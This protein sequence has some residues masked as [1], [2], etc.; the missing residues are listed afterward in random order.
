MKR[1]ILSAVC[2]LALVFGA[3]ASP[4][5]VETVKD[6]FVTASAA[7][8]DTFWNES[9]TMFFKVTGS[10]T[11]ALI[12]FRN[13]SG[14]VTVPAEV[15]GYKVT[16]IEKDYWGI[17]VDDNITE[18]YLPEGMTYICEQAFT[19]MSALTYV[20]F[21]STL[22]YIGIA[23]FARTNIKS[24]D[25][26]GTRLTYVGDSAFAYNASLKSISFPDTLI[27]I[28]G[29]MCEECTELET[30]VLPAE[31]EKIGYCAFSHTK[32]KSVDIPGTCEEIESHSFND[33]SQLESVTLNEGIM[34]IGASAFRSAPLI[35]SVV[36]PGS[37]QSISESAFKECSSLSSVTLN[38]GLKTIG[39]D[40]FRDTALTSIFI[41][42]SVTSIGD[43][44]FLIGQKS[45]RIQG[46]PG[47]EAE[48]YANRRG[49]L[50][51][52]P[53]GFKFGDIN[54]DG[55]IDL[56]DIML[57]KRF[58][59]NLETFDSKMKSRADAHRD[60]KVDTL[61]LMGIKRNILGI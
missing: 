39:K 30:V 17:W 2:A 27:Q 24:A 42:K 59:L 46:Y 12:E 50:I 49:Q 33:C 23:A 58:M 10:N 53:E 25:L 45:C 13:I 56:I 52:T 44:A 7:V 32:I 26:S 14:S 15:K 35:K 38:E 21:P 18:L 22:D 29:H 47:T 6:S 43:Y 51:D 3:A 1:K 31:L 40:V 4:A 20:K 41:P 11:V 34:S 60:Y 19:G 57:L 55:K 5:V 54:D 28:N 36:I 48:L 16:S 61:D 8:G 9:G 37:V